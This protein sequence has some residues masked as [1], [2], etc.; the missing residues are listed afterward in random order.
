MVPNW[1]IW[2]HEEEIE[3]ES[4]LREYHDRIRLTPK[5]KSV[6]R[7]YFWTVG[8][9]AVFVGI[10]GMMS[11]WY[12]FVGHFF[13]IPMVSAFGV[14]LGIAVFNILWLDRN[15]IETLVAMSTA[16]SDQKAYYRLMGEFVERT[17][18]PLPHVA[19][20]K[21][22]SAH[23]PVLAAMS[24]GII[25][26]VIFP[27]VFFE[28]SLSA[29]IG[30]EW[31]QIPVALQTYFLGLFFVGV[32]VGSLTSWVVVVGV[33]Y[34]GVK[35]QELDIRL[36]ITRKRQK[37]GLQPYNR[38]IGMSLFCYFLAYASTTVFA[39]QEPNPVFI[40]GAFIMSSLAI[41]GFIASQYGLHRAIVNSKEKRLAELR[42][43]FEQ[44]LEYWFEHS[45]PNP[46]SDDL[47]AGEMAEFLAVQESI[48][49]IPEWPINITSI[50]GVFS[51]TVASNFWIILQIVGV[52]E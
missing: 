47:G 9:P 5:S 45:E 49:Q 16:F 26:F 43:E 11:W 12:G 25:L 27:P 35:I 42:S 52:I 44:D 21:N 38:G 36:E 39:F 37:L 34:F 50:Y 48:E 24:V 14:V 13:W 41:G 30:V 2:E 40:T 29:L 7:I 8:I 32:I 1:F 17:Y 28:S 23:V 4:D 3:S 46:S 10:G 51:A 20:R 18:E 33:V 22:R 19:R 31:S 6:S 15:G